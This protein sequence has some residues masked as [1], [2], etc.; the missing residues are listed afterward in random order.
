[1]SL[2]MRGGGVE[3]VWEGVVEAG[4]G[5]GWEWEWEAVVEGEWEWVAVAVG[6]EAWEVEGMV[7]EVVE[8]REEEAWAGEVVGEDE[9]EQRTWIDEECEQ[10]TCCRIGEF[11]TSEKQRVH[12]ILL[13]LDWSI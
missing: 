1:M 4:E 8:A 10:L 5:E 7:E 9:A 13:I 6:D 12:H 11:K 2:S 3:G